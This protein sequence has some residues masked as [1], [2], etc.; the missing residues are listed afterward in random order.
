MKN[1]VQGQRV[2]RT[3]NPEDWLNTKVTYVLN[4]EENYIE[5]YDQRFEVNK[6]PLEEEGSFCVE[7]KFSGG[8]NITAYLFNKNEPWQ[9]VDSNDLCS[10]EDDN[11]YDAI[12]KVLA[13]IY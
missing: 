7:L 10:R 9:A 4:T 1:R 5:Y 13:N 12:V 3:I 8:G 11:P 6:I 2:E